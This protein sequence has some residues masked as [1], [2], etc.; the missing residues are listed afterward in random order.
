MD[1]LI[2]N[3]KVE[4]YKLGWLFALIGAIFGI[5]VNILVFLNTYYNM[6][7]AEERKAGGCGVIVEYFLPAYTDI[8][9]LGG[10]LYTIAFVGFLNKKSWAYSVATAGNICAL[11]ASFWTMVPALDGGIF[12]MYVFLFVPNVAIFVLLHKITGNQPWSRIKLGL[13]TGIAM[14]LAFMN[15]VAGTNRMMVIGWPIFTATQRLTWVAAI[16]LGITTHS[17]FNGIKEWTVPVAFG[18]ALLEVAI[19]FPMAVASSISFEKFSMFFLAPFASLVILI[20][21]WFPF[22]KKMF[23]PEEA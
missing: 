5:G 11:Q 18:A 15:G 7:A 10:V 22:W 21:P 14:V 13:L 4:Q 12:P 1:D 6:I 8:G 19:G 9:I 2:K 3:E 17:I 16:G 23:P 20:I